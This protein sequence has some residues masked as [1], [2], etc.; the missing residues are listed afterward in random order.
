MEP[1]V[2]QDFYLLSINPKNGYYFNFG[3]EFTYGLMGALLMDLYRMGKIDFQNKNVFLVDQT[4]TDYPFFNR[5]SE[6][7]KHRKIPL[8]A[9]GLISRIGFR[10]R[11][12]KKEIANSL[13]E[14]KIIIRVRK[15]FLFIPYNRYYPFNRDTR[16]SIVHRYRD[17]LLRNEMPETDDMYLLSLIHATGLYKALSD[18]RAERKAMRV[19]M[20]TILQKNSG[21][22]TKQGNIIMLAETLK[23]VII[24]TNAAQHAH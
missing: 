13:V 16:L 6:L 8:K 10:C 23:R 1:K 3:N 22:N 17:I 24:A 19:K 12:Y 5:A 9:Y 21:F 14:N 18:Q 4:S 15:K 7:I 2:V 20:K 11:T